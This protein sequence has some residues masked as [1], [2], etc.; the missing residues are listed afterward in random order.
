MPI[1]YNEEWIKVRNGLNKKFRDAFDPCS[2]CKTFL[3]ELVWY[4]IKS[5][6]IRC[7]WCFT[8]S[9]YPDWYGVEKALRESRRRR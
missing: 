2:I 3:C 1:V 4:N 8:P 5:K 6:E 7:R 9:E